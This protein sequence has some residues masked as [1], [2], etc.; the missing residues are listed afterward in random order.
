MRPVVVEVKSVAGDV[1]QKV[2]AYTATRVT[3][4]MTNFGW[5]KCTQQWSH[6][7]I[8]TAGELQRGQSLTFL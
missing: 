7:G 1:K 6:T 5:S 4:T 2:T 8:S 3:G